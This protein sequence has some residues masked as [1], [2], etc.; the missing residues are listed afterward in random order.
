MSRVEARIRDLLV[1]LDQPAHP[2]RSSDSSSSPS[3]IK[4]R[5]EPDNMTVTTRA[6]IHSPSEHREWQRDLERFKVRSLSLF[7]PLLLPHPCGADSSFLQN[8]ATIPYAPTASSVASPNTVLRERE[9][10]SRKL[11]NLSPLSPNTFEPFESAGSFFGAHGGGT[12]AARSRDPFAGT[13]VVEPTESGA[14]R[15]APQQS[16]RHLVP[17]QVRSLSISTSLS[18]CL[19]TLALT[20]A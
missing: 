9:R 3:T 1:N 19:R 4:A 7:R 11:Q 12:A 13:G 16:H 15:Q 14:A 8:D 17:A 2:S 5:A 6:G 10:A 18:C 20:L